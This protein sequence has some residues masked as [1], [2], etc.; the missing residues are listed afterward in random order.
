MIIINHFP[1]LRNP[2]TKKLNQANLMNLMN[3]ATKTNKVKSPALFAIRTS[4]KTQSKHNADMNS[5]GR[6]LINGYI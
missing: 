4:S 1:Q 6:V 3:P 5:A 2:T